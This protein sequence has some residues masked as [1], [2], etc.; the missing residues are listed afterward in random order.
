METFGAVAYRLCIALAVLSVVISLIVFAVSGSVGEE[1]PL[2]LGFVFAVAFYLIGKA[3]LYVLTGKWAPSKK[4]EIVTRSRQVVSCMVA[5]VMIAAPVI[6]Y[7]WGAV[8]QWQPGRPYL[9]FFILGSVCIAG[10]IWLYDEVRDIRAEAKHASMASENPFRAWNPEAF[11]KGLNR[12]AK[13]LQRVA[14]KELTESEVA[15]ALQT[16]LGNEVAAR[17]L[18]KNPSS[19]PDQKQYILDEALNAICPG[20]REAAYIAANLPTPPEHNERT[21]QGT[22]SGLGRAMGRAIGIWIF[23]LLASGIIGALIGSAIA[24][25]YASDWGV[26]GFCAGTFTF[27]C[28][29]LWLAGSKNSK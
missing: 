2:F 9:V 27:A 4:P 26:W 18:R 6:V 25:L 10:I 14:A 12:W 19:S 7:F 24:S 28:L 5:G 1:H 16:A 15:V 21:V 22:H 3:G 8:V 29:R 23:G 20:V 13:E 11:D 17:V